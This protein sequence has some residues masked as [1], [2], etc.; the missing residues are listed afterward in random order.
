MTKLAMLNLS[1]SKEF[2]DIG[3]RILVPIHD[4]ILIEV[5]IHNYQKAEELLSSL[6]SEA[7]NFLPFKIS[8]DVETTIR[9]YGLSFPCPYPKPV[10]I[11]TT[12]SEEVKW[13]QY[14]LT[15]CEYILPVFPD[16][17]GEKPRGDAARGVNG[18]YS[19]ELQQA[20]SDYISKYRITD[21]KFIDH[22]E[23]KIIYGV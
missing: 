10:S 20:I 9:W 18:E 19:D 8:C 21:D 11:Y 14:M 23:S 17:N 16:E 5:P 22:I 4:E 6:M 15:E 13:L 7:G 3:A 1:N 12:D 2:K